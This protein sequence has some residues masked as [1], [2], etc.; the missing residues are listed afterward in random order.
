MKSCRCISISATHLARRTTRCILT[1][2][3]L[4]T[5]HLATRARLS[6]IAHLAGLACAWLLLFALVDLASAQSWLP[7][8]PAAMLPQREPAGHVVSK[9][10]HPSIARIVVPEKSGASFGSGSLIDVRG[11]HGLVVTNWHVVRDASGPIYCFFGDGYQS[12]AT[13]VKVD[14]DWDLAALSVRK[15]PKAVP[16]P[17]TQQ[18]PRAGDWLCIAGYGSGDYRAAAGRCTQYVSP[19]TNLPYE[20]VEVAAEARQGDSGG[21]ILNERGELAGVLFGS[22]SGTTS[23]SYAGRVLNF[24]QG[25][26]PAA[27]QQTVAQQQV[28]PQQPAPAQRG[29]PQFPAMVTGAPP[30]SDAHLFAATDPQGLLP[31]QGSGEWKPREASAA[32][33]P[34]VPLAAEAYGLAPVAE[35]TAVPAAPRPLMPLPDRRSEPLTLVNGEEPLGDDRTALR[36]APGRN[37]IMARDLDLKDSAAGPVPAEALNVLHTPLPARIASSTPLETAPADQLLAAAWKQVGGSTL[38][39]QGKT[40]L[41][42]LGIL[43]LLIQFW[44]M[45][46]RPDAIGDDD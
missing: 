14:R 18:A 4:R 40:L 38:F 44:R 20:M 12:E 24:L 3:K 46:S 19:A 2:F 28:T 16:V 45:N 9:T 17:I 37:P 41:A 5:S 32:M 21:P 26:V 13:I 22:G 15:P 8:Q 1:G 43:G 42:V 11:E 7:I 36:P 23:G 34:A 6:R 25:V 33:S 30:A 27:Q 39:D 29:A 10:P 31:S 35:T